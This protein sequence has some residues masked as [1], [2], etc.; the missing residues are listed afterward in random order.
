MTTERRP[1]LFLYAHELASM[2]EYSLSVPTGTTVG[3]VWKRRVPYN[4]PELQ[5]SWV[6]GMYV[7]SGSLGHLR[8]VWS[9]VVL[10]SGPALRR[11]NAPDWSNF[12]AWCAERQAERNKS[13]AIHK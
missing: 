1:E 4:A 13:N 12:A 7:Y 8:I 2:P 10:R 9:D 3:K 11:Y 5:A 6:I